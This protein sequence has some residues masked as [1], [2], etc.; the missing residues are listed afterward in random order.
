MKIF[1]LFVSLILTV[2][3]SFIYDKELMNYGENFF[4]YKNKLPWGIKPVA[5][6]NFDGGIFFVD[7]TG[8]QFL[9]TGIIGY[10]NIDKEISIANIDKYWYN[11]NTFIVQIKDSNN[12]KCYIILTENKE[13]KKDYIINVTK[14]ITN[15]Y[16]NKFKKIELDKI[17]IQH[18][19]LKRTLFILFSLVIMTLLIIRFKKYTK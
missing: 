14:S 8:F 13:N 5:R 9:G 11:E 12:S 3:V 17:A 18:T 16:V 10:V 7:Y 6:S 4:P 19:I 1:V 2:T 15:M